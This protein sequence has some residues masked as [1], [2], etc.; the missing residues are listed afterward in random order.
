MT[1]LVKVN[2]DIVVGI[3]VTMA[4]GARFVAPAFTQV[5]ST[6]TEVSF[7]A[8]ATA[9]QVQGSAAH[10]AAVVG[11]PVRIGARALTGGYTPVQTGDVADLVATLSGSLIV[12][13]YSI[14]DADWQAAAP[15]GGITNST[16]AV[17]LKAAAGG[18]LRNYITA[19]QVSS[20][21]LG[22][23]TELVIRDGAAGTVIWRIKLATAGTTGIEQIQFPTPLKSSASTLLEV[24][25]LTA[26]VTGSVFVSAQGYV[27]P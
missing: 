19:I 11:N 2:G 18:S 13:P 14:P 24:A 3:P 1:N 17:T 9:Q 8:G 25:T 6:G 7:G 16:T 22:A 26:S 21:V 23:A 20:D 15:A 10:D 4:D 12:K 5:D 27:A